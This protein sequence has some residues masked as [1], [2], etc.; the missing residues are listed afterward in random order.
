MAKGP[1]QP[2]KRSPGAGA[3]A[4]HPARAPL[5][6]RPRRLLAAA[7]AAL[8][9]LCL[10][11]VLRQLPNL[12]DRAEYRIAPS[13]VTMTQAP[14][15]IP[16]DL[17]T[18]VFESS[19]LSAEECLQDATLSE[20]IAAAF[21]T[22]PWI[23]RVV[24]VRKSFPARVHVDVVYRE[25]VAMV[26]GIDGHYPVDR[27]GVLL[28]ARDFTDADLDRYPVIEG[29]ASVPVGQLGEAW[30]DAAVVGAARVASALLSRRA[31][32]ETWWHQLELATIQ[33]PR[34]VVLDE[35]ADDL[36]FVL[37]TRGGSEILWG[38]QPGTAFPGELSIEQKLE[39]LAEFHQD[40][41]S[42][43]DQHGPYRIDIRPWQ[44][45]GR[46]T[47]AREPDRRGVR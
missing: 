43:D 22:H 35:S 18:Q 34:K 10:P 32:G 25:P 28:P 44:G 12:D 13:Q 45:I 17:V 14:R 42:F 39:R 30:G 9:L 36:E 27:A 5:L 16:P 29:V 4:A 23:E 7:S 46:T 2:R 33:V 38:R 41:G 47:I 24:S 15:W 11:L 8:G 40:Y 6:F 21:H 31:D 1:G 37:R 3:A 26:R 19:G 20:R